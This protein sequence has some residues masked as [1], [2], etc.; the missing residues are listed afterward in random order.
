MV[1]PIT[2]ERV[3]LFKELA[4]D[5]LKLISAKFHRDTYSEDKVIFNQGD[6]AE[7]LYVLLSGSVAIRFKPHDGETIHVTDVYEGDVF[8]WSAALGRHVYTSCAIATSACEM[9]Y[10]KGADLRELCTSQPEIGVVILERLATVIAERLRNTHA[11]VV[12]LLWK[13]VNEDDTR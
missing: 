4:D 11:Q 8:G 2:L 1:K 5:H 3:N 6:P 9:V 13:S 10:I 12:D 7:S